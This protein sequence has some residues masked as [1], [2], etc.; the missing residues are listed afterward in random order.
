MNADL[1]EIEQSQMAINAKYAIWFNRATLKIMVACRLNSPHHLVHSMRFNLCQTDPSSAMIT[2]THT[3][4]RD[5]CKIFGTKFS[6]TPVGHEC[7]QLQVLLVCLSGSEDNLEV[8]Q[9]GQGGGGVVALAP[10]KR[11]SGL[12]EWI[13]SGRC[14]KSEGGARGP[15]MIFGFTT[16]FFCWV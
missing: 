11:N 14:E 10:S 16:L 15:H 13:W 7:M 4:T 6:E 9:Q 8:S 12:T 5:Q 2:H 1:C 3:G